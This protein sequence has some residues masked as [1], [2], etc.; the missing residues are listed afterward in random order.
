MRSDPADL[1]LKN[2]ERLIAKDPL[3]R[4]IVNPTLPAA[5]RSA[6]CNPAVDVI[7]TEESWV[8]L[9]DLPGVE[10]EGLQVRLDGTRLTISGDKPSLRSG[11]A[12]VS[13]RESG[14]FSRDF[15]LPFQVN[16]EGIKA[17]LENGVLEVT[18]PRA[19]KATVRTVTVE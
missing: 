17:K 16:A 4:D 1:A 7:E 3:L 5:K 13:E 6:R 8:L 14:P 2:L 10:R 18:L 11:R 9:V 15:L 12:R 19:G